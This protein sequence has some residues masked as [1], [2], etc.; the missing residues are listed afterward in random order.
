MNLGCTIWKGSS[1]KGLREHGRE[2]IIKKMIQGTLSRNQ[3]HESLNLK[4]SLQTAK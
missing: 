4:G 1:K 3:I 2:E